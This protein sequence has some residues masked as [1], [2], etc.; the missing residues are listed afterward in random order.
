MC[1]ADLYTY[2]AAIRPRIVRDDAATLSSLAPRAYPSPC[3]GN[4]ASGA[5]SL[6][7]S[8][9]RCGDVTP[10]RRRVRQQADGPGNPFVREPIT[11]APNG[12]DNWA[13][14]RAQSMLT[15]DGKVGP[16]LT[17]RCAMQVIAGVHLIH[18]FAHASEPHRQR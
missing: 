11:A 1:L 2:P 6:S 9:V 4:R 17:P 16:V 7:G 14:Y 5:T 13:I 12:G 18:H 10:M 3:V 8:S 15:V